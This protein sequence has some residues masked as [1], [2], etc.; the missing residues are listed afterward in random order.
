MDNE[1]VKGSIELWRRDGRWEMLIRAPE[2]V[3]DD[4]VR[5]APFAILNHGG[6]P[7]HGYHMLIGRWIH[8]DTAETET[9]EQEVAQSSTGG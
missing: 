1:Y 9:K 7:S 5:E 6:G 8:R 2:W 3:I 4:V